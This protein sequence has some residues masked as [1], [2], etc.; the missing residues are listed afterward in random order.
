MYSHRSSLDVDLSKYVGE[1]Y[2]KGECS[3]ERM[4]RGQEEILVL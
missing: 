2:P 3:S 1:A 4:Q